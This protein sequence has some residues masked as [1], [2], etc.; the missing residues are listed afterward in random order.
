MGHVFS[1]WIEIL[2]QSTT[3]R[4]SHP[5]KATVRRRTEGLS[6]T[7][8]AE[9]V[10]TKIADEQRLAAFVVRCHS[11]P[12]AEGQAAKEKEIA[13]R[14]KAL[15]GYEVFS[16]DVLEHPGVP[17]HVVVYRHAQDQ[18]SS[19]EAPLQTMDQVLLNVLASEDRSAV[20][21]FARDLAE[22]VGAV[23]RVYQGLSG[24]QTTISGPEYYQRVLRRLPSDIVIDA[25]CA[26]VSLE[27][28]LL[29]IPR[30]DGSLPP[31]D[32]A[33]SSE[34][35]LEELHTE[36]SYFTTARKARWVRFKGYLCAQP[37][38]RNH[39]RLENEGRRVML[40]V[41]D[42]VREQLLT[43]GSGV[44]IAFHLADKCARLSS[45]ILQ[46]IGLHE[47]SLLDAAKLATICTP[48][49]K[50]SIGAQH[51]DLHCGNVLHSSGRFKVIDVESLGKELL[52]S[53]AA[54]LETSIWDCLARAGQ[55]RLTAEE[56]RE[57]LDSVDAADE[58]I[59]P[60][61][62]FVPWALSRILAGI[63][64][65]VLTTQEERQLASEEITLAYLIQILMYQRYWIEEGAHGAARAIP[66]FL[67]EYVHHWIAKAT[68]CPIHPLHA[69]EVEPLADTERTD[70]ADQP[71]RYALWREAMVS[72]GSQILRNDAQK[73]LE[74]LVRDSP[75]L[76]QGSLTAL[77]MD[78]WDKRDKAPF[79]SD[80]HV[81]ITG[82]TSSGKSTLADM[83]L[84][85]P[86]LWAD[87][88]VC[89]VYIAPT[90]ALAR[91]KHREL[92]ALFAGVPRLKDGTVIS[93]H[94]DHDDDWRITHGR[95]CV[96]C[97]VYEKANIL[98]SS[99]RTL[100]NRVGC[101]VI[102]EMHMLTDLERGPILE[103]VL[104]KAVRERTRIDY[105]ATRIP[106]ETIRIV[107]IST[108]DEP[109]DA[110]ERLM[111][112]KDTDGDGD[113]KLPL[114]IHADDRPMP[115]THWIVC[116]ASNT[117]GFT[118]IEIVRF[119]A[120]TQRIL[121][122]EQK[123]T[124]ERRLVDVQG[125]HAQFSSMSS[126]ERSRQD[127]R[128]VFVALLL[129][130]VRSR[131]R[132]YRVL[133]FI[134]SRA[135]VEDIARQLKNDI[136]ELQHQGLIREVS[137]E[138]VLKA[139]H[140]DV[141]R[142]EDGETAKTILECA[143]VGILIHHADIVPSVR[144]SIETVCAMADANMPSQILLATETLSYGVNLAVNDVVLFGTDFHTQTRKREHMKLP[145]AP[146]AFH[147][148]AGRAGR[149]GKLTPGGANVFI[150]T[151]GDAASGVVTR[152]YSRID[153]VDSRLFVADDRRPM[154]A[155]RELPF[156]VL[157]SDTDL[158]ACLRA[159]DFTHPFV[160]SVLDGLRHM[161]LWDR[162][163]LG[164]DVATPVTLDALL[165][166]LGWTLFGR[167]LQISRKTDTISKFPAAV[168]RILDDCALEPLLLVKAEPGDQRRYTLLPIGKAIID[169]GTELTTVEPLLAIVHEVRTVWRTLKTSDRFPAE[170]YLLCLIAQEE[171]YRQYLLYTPECRGMGR[172]A[173]WNSEMA[174]ANR[175]HVFGQLER[176]LRTLRVTEP[177]LVA[178]GVRRIL[179]EWK[180]I[181]S[182]KEAYE[183]AASDSL[184]R[185][186]SALVAWVHGEPRAAV[187]DTIEKTV[188]GAS[189]GRMQGF[190]QF[191]ELLGYKTI[192]LSKMLSS[193]TSSEMAFR[194]DDE[195]D[196]N[197]LS[198]RLRLGCTSTAIPLFW[199]HKS[200]FNR[201]SAGHLVS[202]GLTPETILAKPDL[203]GALGA[204]R[205]VK[206][207]DLEHLRRD[208]EAYAVKEFEELAAHFTLALQSEGNEASV[209]RMWDDMQDLFRVAVQSFRLAGDAPTAFDTR[210]RGHLDFDFRRLSARTHAVRDRLY[211]I[212]VGLPP[213]GNGLLLRGERSS[214]ERDEDDQ[215]RWTEHATVRAVCVQVGR[216]WK[217]SVHEGMRYPLA[218][219][220][221]EE[222]IAKH[223]LV[224]V[225]P[226]LPSH[227]IPAD[228]KRALEERAARP[229]YSLT[230]ATPA[231]YGVLVTLLARGFTAGEEF[232]SSFLANSPTRLDRVLD[233]KTIQRALDD[234][235][236]A[237]PPAIREKMIQ[238]FEVGSPD[239]GTAT[240]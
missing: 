100:L 178:E 134:P 6:D 146:S 165:D 94:E 51:I 173:D 201:Q 121:S 60:D 59:S 231:A 140:A 240:L 156:R 87:T 149:L 95:F 106:A 187:I 230:F 177:V 157:G 96:A 25:R 4:D 15:P 239:E 16:S 99:N 112:V 216:E 13:G 214:G 93:T 101:L 172:A 162:P 205:E 141:E 151:D 175:R 14:L 130:K 164:D 237:V 126:T 18:L 74:S 70:Q 160:R 111:A 131:P 136:K 115:V 5:V 234:S 145:L 192:F 79:Q 10:F 29:Q 44:M 219:I 228:L 209:R 8:V 204:S 52:V 215:G 154:D 72:P 158:Y 91:A 22:L 139:L 98:F 174:E 195:R 226:W 238:H 198:S 132:G 36:L 64:K 42:D 169:T 180:P 108:E 113:V 190:R 221:E 125:Q 137:R 184:L 102:D 182:V 82:P 2:S 118:C 212:M 11:G 147:N 185:L 54:R 123:Q 207:P 218:T 119:E 168:Q 197:M 26:D 129:Q 224:V 89:S 37:A 86:P 39:L 69:D 65:A 83:F 63:R 122:R 166:F 81:I 202:V 38:G 66:P 150:V 28:N 211:R 206:W 33:R 80:S 23:A 75:Q 84:A 32:P 116:P 40:L 30:E 189:E 135:E 41:S 48:I 183:N 170:L 85:G 21:E 78:L 49:G 77:Q 155:V 76:T 199:P 50:M 67:D 161:N 53:A 210:M 232:M 109:G 235:S 233:V 103:L 194:S 203:E 152:Y 217:G 148:M 47:T 27:G 90:R 114:R 213:A 88:R 127:L 104:T 120:S 58:R 71:T 163:V 110:F 61:D 3:T 128:K 186:F 17:K 144:R 43:M 105:E 193:S 153:P 200:D 57:I 138:P 20:E 171:I 7:E 167:Q 143:S 159:V 92:Q 19:A 133:A 46:D 107:A 179:N 229:E 191:T 56:A 124:I 45:A 9:I 220:L 222:G 62:S 97:M 24:D 73:L 31:S 223:L 68:Q 188:L 225:F 1:G 176:S 196:L 236:V 227:P 208:L 12:D 117:D 142:M 55:T 34:L 35:T 181:R